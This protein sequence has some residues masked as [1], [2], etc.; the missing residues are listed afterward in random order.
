MKMNMI[1]M[2]TRNHQRMKQRLRVVQN[3]MIAVQMKM[4]KK[5]NVEEEKNE[6]NK[7]QGKKKTNRHQMMNLMMK[8]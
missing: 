7:R 5:K 4:Q 3:L 6:G 8:R 2:K 1:L